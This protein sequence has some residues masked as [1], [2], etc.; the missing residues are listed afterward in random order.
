MNTCVGSS[1]LHTTNL[2]LS[3]L[4]PSPL[5]QSI[6]ITGAGIVSPL[7]LGWQ[8]NEQSLATDR[9]ALDACLFGGRLWGSMD[10]QQTVAAAIAAAADSTR[11]R[12][13]QHHTHSSNTEQP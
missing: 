3:S 13:K 2:I 10:I 7:G 5:R 11:A 1:T 8:A 4:V 9:S 12:L 6:A